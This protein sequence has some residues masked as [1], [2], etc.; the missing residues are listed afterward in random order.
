MIALTG[1]TLTGITLTDVMTDDIASCINASDPELTA[2]DPELS[3]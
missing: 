1:I 3:W 2:N